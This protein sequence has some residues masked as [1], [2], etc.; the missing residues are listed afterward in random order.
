MCPKGPRQKRWLVLYKIALLEL[1]LQKMPE[2]IV[3]AIK[4]LRERS[5]RLQGSHG[6]YGEKLE[7]EYALRNL[8]IAAK[9]K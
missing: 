2:R 7:I 3:S 4:A 9:M 6:H 5:R 1:D 8:H